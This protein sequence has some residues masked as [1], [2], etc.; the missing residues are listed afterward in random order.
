MML[1][2]RRGDEKLERSI[3]AIRVQLKNAKL[4]VALLY[5]RARIC[6]VLETR[7][8]VVMNVMTRERIEASR[9]LDELATRSPIY[10]RGPESG[11]YRRTEKK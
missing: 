10:T 3:D 8:W 1:H 11:T 4:R 5:P 9:S 7:E 6:W 2:D